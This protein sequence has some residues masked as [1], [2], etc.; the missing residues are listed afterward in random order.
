LRATLQQVAQ[1]RPEQVAQVRPE[2][3]AQ[4]RPE[5]LEQLERLVQAQLL[6]GRP[7]KHQLRDF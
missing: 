5:Q 1:V 4:V 3:V 7:A 2:Q 6:R